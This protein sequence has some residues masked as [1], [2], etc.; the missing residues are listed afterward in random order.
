MSDRIRDIFISYNKSDED[1]ATKLARRIEK[2][3]IEG[4]RLTTWFAPWDIDGGDNIV[5]KIEDGLLKSK[6][7]GIIMSPDWHQSPWTNLERS[8]AVF[9]DPSNL[10]GKIIPILFRNCEIPPTLQILKWYD[11]RTE[12]NF[13]REIKKIITK[14][15]GK[16]LTRETNLRRQS[17]SLSVFPDKQ[18]ELLVT[19]LFSIIKTPTAVYSAKT[20]IDS[21]YNIWQQIPGADP[22]P[23]AGP[24]ARHLNILSFFNPTNNSDLKQILTDIPIKLNVIDLISD[25]S[26]EL[27]EL[28]NRCMTRY[29]KHINLEYDHRR[30]VKKNFFTPEDDDTKC[31]L[32]R[33]VKWKAGKRRVL[34]RIPGSNP[35]YAHQSCK[36]NFTILSKKLFLRIIPSWHF[37]I[38][39]KNPVDNTRMNSFTSRWMNI[40]KN[41]S[42]LNHLRFWANT[43]SKN[44]D[45]IVLHTGSAD[46]VTIRS[47]PVFTKIG[48]GV[49]GDYVDRMWA[50][51]QTL[52]DIEDTELNEAWDR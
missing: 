19:N 3:E 14:L 21:R 22:P 44:S 40:E 1:F 23:F 24:S 20:N 29:I 2:E 43:L 39:G 38:D 37:T 4:K 34:K 48:V 9:N 45:R 17:S 50:D 36:I 15:Q 10:C 31:Q 46:N 49:E 12:R 41:R 16:A 7:I 26:N 33:Y 30:N 8:I 11:F 5:L 27:V 51:T 25:N 18:D 42:I 13:E 6:H 47:L 32:A 52:G 35:Y 28:L